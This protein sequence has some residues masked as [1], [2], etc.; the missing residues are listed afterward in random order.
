MENIINFNDGVTT[1]I[2]KRFV[3]GVDRSRMRLYDVE[4]QAQ[5]D[6]VDSG[7]SQKP[8]KKSFEGFKV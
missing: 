4:Q 7:S 5:N 8:Q 2:N 3:I 1:S 6:I